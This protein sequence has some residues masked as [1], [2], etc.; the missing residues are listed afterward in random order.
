[1]GVLDHQDIVQITNIR[2]EQRNVSKIRWLNLWIQN[3]QR[4]PKQLIPYGY[5]L[6]R[7]FD[8]LEKIA[9]LFYRE[10]TVD[11]VTK[12]HLVLQRSQIPVVMKTVHNKMGHL[13]RDKTTSVLQD[14][15]WSGM[16]RDVEEWIQKCRRSVLRN[17]LHSELRLSA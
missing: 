8:Y 9:G 14:R 10:T 17:P 7:S 6:V 4:P 13:G 5:K 11:G 3:R 12:R 16:T 15:Y 2:D 1:V